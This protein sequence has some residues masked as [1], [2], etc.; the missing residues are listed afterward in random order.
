MF[1]VV[2]Y[3]FYEVSESVVSCVGYIICMQNLLFKD[4]KLLYSVLPEYNRKC[5]YCSNIIRTL[6][7]FGVSLL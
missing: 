6:M 3:Q 2:D 5:Q 4:N 1:I 7:T